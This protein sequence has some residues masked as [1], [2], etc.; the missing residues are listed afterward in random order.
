MTVNQRLLNGYMTVT[1]RLLNDYTSTPSMYFATSSLMTTLIV[2]ITADYYADY[3]ARLRRR[4]QL[5]VD[6]LSD[7][8]RRLVLPHVYEMFKRLL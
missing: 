2:L 5:G 4:A 8:L 1:Q 6:V 7:E 3:Y